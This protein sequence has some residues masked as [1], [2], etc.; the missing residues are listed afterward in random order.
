MLSKWTFNE[1]FNK[2]RHFCPNLDDGNNIEILLPIVK[3]GSKYSD[4]I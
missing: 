3:T 4:C 1:T 2:L